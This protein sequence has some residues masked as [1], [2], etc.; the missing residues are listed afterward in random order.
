MTAA[1]LGV[2]WG[3]S[4]LRVLRIAPG[5]DVLDSRSDPRGAGGLGPEDFPR[6]LSEVAGDWLEPALPVL[7]C[8]MAGARGRWREMD[9]LP[10]PA[11]LSDLAAG[12]ASPDGRPDIRIVP[13]LMTVSGGKM[14]D[15]MRGEE[16]QIMGLDL[17][18]GEHRIVAPGTH[19]KWIAA[20]PGRIDGHR[21]FMTGELFAAIRKGTL[22][23]IGMGEPGIDSGAFADGVSRGLDDPALTAALFS[24]RVATLAGRLGADATADYLSGLLIGAEIAANVSDADRPVTLV[25]AGALNTAYETALRIAG[26]SDIRV[27]DGAAATARGL[28]RIHEASQ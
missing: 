9:Y 13:G 10:A 7:V 21:T 2:D 23:G 18:P 26:F 19:S 15:V 27:A 3:T 28:W 11:T 17:E 22:L 8:G 6:V 24:I 14:V 20:G 16:T 25:G 12:V 4:N 1:L 5:G